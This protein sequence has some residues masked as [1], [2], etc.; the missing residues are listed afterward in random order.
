[1][2]WAWKLSDQ[3]SLAIEQIKLVS[4]AGELDAGLDEERQA[5]LRA[6]G[7]DDAREGI[8]AFLEKRPPRFGDR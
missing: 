7:S 1:M 5:F 4:A 6:F 2:A 8:A 3:P